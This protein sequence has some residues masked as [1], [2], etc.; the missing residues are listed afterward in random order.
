MKGDEEWLEIKLW[1]I[2]KKV[3]MVENKNTSLKI[4]ALQ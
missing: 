3:T 1:L 2:Q 4:S